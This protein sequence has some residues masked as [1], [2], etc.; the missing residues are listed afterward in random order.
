MGLLLLVLQL[1]VFVLSVN[2]ALHF[3]G[4]LVADGWLEFVFVVIIE[5]LREHVADGLALGVAHQ[6]DGSVDVFGYELM[7]QAVSTSI[8]VED[9]VGFP[10]AQIVQE[11]TSRYA[12]FAHE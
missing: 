4:F 8:A 6:M 11:L 1:Q 2:E 12:Y 3:L 10:I 9:E 5:D 7:E